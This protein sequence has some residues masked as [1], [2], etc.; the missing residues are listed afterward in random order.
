MAKS[1]GKAVAR[2][3]IE[4]VTEKPDTGSG[5]PDLAQDAYTFKKEIPEIRWRGKDGKG[6]YRMGD[7]YRVASLR[8]EQEVAAAG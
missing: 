4:L 6:D 2:I 3:T 1:T 7:K 8:V 5:M